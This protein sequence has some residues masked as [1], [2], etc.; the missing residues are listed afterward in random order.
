MAYRRVVL[1]G[2]RV[3][4]TKANLD[5]YLTNK[6][7]KANYPDVKVKIIVSPV[8][9]DTIVVDLNGEGADSVSKKVKDIGGKYQMVAKIKNEKPLSPQIK[10]S[11]EK[12]LRSLIREE[13]KSIIKESKK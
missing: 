2:T 1:T 7:F 5:D 12:E 9:E 10:E 6:L 8:K 4:D 3:K 13:I 11:K